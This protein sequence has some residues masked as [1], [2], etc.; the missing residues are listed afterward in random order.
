MPLVDVLKEAVLRTEC[1]NAVTTAA[2]RGDLA[3]EV[4]AERLMLA[5]YAY[6]TNTGIRSV[7]GGRHGHS[8]DDLRYVRRRYL[9]PRDRPADR[10]RDR[11]RHVRGPLSQRVGRR[12]DRRCLGLAAL[13]RV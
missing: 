8:E 3:P 13:R 11:Q 4:L 10:R 6:G 9:T 7:A 2:G 5:V 1:L 12:L